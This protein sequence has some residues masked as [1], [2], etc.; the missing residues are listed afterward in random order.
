[1]A[2]SSATSLAD[3]RQSP[4]T[5]YVPVPPNTRKLMGF[6]IRS[7]GMDSIWESNNV[8]MATLSEAMAVRQSA[9]LKLVTG[10]ITAPT[11]NLQSA[12]ISEYP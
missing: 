11:L 12:L 3:I 7:V 2:V 5:E 1:M 9:K 6:A 10:A 8:M 4:S